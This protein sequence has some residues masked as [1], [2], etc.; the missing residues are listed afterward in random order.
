MDCRM[1][2]GPEIF[3][4]C[5]DKAFVILKNN[6]H[7]NKYP[8]IKIY[9]DLKNSIIQRFNVDELEDNI[10][11][12]HGSFN[13]AERIIHKLLTPGLLLGVG[14]QF[15][16]IPSE[17]QSAGGKLVFI[18][19]FNNFSNIVDSVIKKV[20]FLNPTVIYIDRPN[21]PTGWVMPIKDIHKLAI[22]CHKRNIL[23]FIDEAFGDFIDDS[24]SIIHLIKQYNN[25][26]VIRSFSKGFGLA[27]FRVGYGIFSNNIAPYIKNI[28]PPFE[29]SLYS[30]NVALCANNVFFRLNDVRRDVKKYKEKIYTKLSAIGLYWY[31]THDAVPLIVIH[32][33]LKEKNLFQYF[34]KYGI[35]AEPLSSYKITYPSANNH[36][37]KLSLPF[38]EYNRSKLLSLLDKMKI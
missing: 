37:I 32:D 24:E 29:P 33:H 8:D 25:I 35:L 31:N 6:F 22:L 27:S 9:N 1:S 38:D 34:M 19:R 4:D 23:L 15:N 11:L 26:A 36:S 21:N 28:F 14:P 7:P 17:F 20:D 18:S 30:T 3:F 2:S 10:F 13:I 5:I 12:G 16:E